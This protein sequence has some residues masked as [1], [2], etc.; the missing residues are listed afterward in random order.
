MS[1]AILSPNKKS[2]SE[3]SS[4]WDLSMRKGVVR[5]FPHENEKALENQGLFL[6]WRV[7]INLNSAL[8]I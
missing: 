2:H 7:K 3:I 5:D 6:A 8:A 4:K 1:V